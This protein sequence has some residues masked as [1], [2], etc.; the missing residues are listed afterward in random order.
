M[1]C[2]I[3]GYFAIKPL[4]AVNACQP[5]GVQNQFGDFSERCHQ[6]DHFAAIG[7]MTQHDD[8][9]RFA[10]K[11]AFYQYDLVVIRGVIQ[12]TVLQVRPIANA[13]EGS[14]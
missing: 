8:S 2:K 9:T 6:I 1:R 5:P 12:V 7:I 11:A 4:M 14:G 10:A 3:F 13:D